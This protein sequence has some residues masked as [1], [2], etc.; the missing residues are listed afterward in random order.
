MISIYFRL[1]EL[2]QDVGRGMDHRHAAVSS[3]LHKPPSSPSIGMQPQLSRQ[4]YLGLKCWGLGLAQ[5]AWWWWWWRWHW[6]G[7]VSQTSAWSGW[8][9][10]SSAIS[11]PSKYH[12]S[13]LTMCNWS[14][15]WMW[16]IFIFNSLENFT[17]NILTK[18]GGEQNCREFVRICLQI[19]LQLKLGRR[20]HKHW[21][22]ATRKLARGTKA[23][24]G[25]IFGI[26]S[27]KLS[28][29]HNWVIIQSRCSETILEQ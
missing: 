10:K 22:K 13:I 20:G 16:P 12:L 26:S 27:G 17:Q 6:M 3:L 5:Q 11:K 7:Q 4:K 18:R 24:F 8:N 29:Y 21:Q 9:F 14:I 1:K 23:L 2:L 15:W 19:K 28:I 25:A